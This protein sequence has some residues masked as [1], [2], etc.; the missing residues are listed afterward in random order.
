MKVHVLGKWSSPWQNGKL[1][2]EEAKRQ[3]LNVSL[4][5]LEQP[6]KEI[7]KAIDREKPD[8]VFLTG[9]RTLPSEI[10]K[11]IKERANLLLWDADAN[12]EGRRKPWEECL[13][14]PDIIVTS[15]LAI[16]QEYKEKSKRI[17]WIPQYFDSEYH[18][19]ASEV[20]SPEQIYDI[21]FLGGLNKSRQD[22]LTQLS[23]TFKV[24]Y[25]SHMFGSDM[26][27]AY[28]Q[29][30]IAIGINWNQS[31]YEYDGSFTTS[32]RIFKAMGCGVFYLANPVKNIELLFKPGIHLDMYDGSFRHMMEKVEYWVSHEKER[33]EIAKCGQEEIF[34]N[35]ALNVRIKQYWELMTSPDYVPPF[36]KGF[37]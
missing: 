33:L 13:H 16:A 2:Y 30:K 18:Q 15:V 17:V 7:L 26:V 24:A 25:H 6:H 35:H 20:P 9:S 14:I 27:Y 19:M 11:E 10:L 21:I 1:I 34:K 3:K 8:W 32:D 22:M 28:K 37:I 5:V 4:G 36:E 12:S 29:T 31:S 23:Q